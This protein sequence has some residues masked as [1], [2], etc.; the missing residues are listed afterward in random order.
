MTTLSNYIEDHN[1]DGVEIDWEFL[2]TLQ[3]VNPIESHATVWLF[4]DFW[5]VLPFDIALS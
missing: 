2:P 3:K 4:S 1:I 5:F